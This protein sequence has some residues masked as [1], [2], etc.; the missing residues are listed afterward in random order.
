MP[1]ASKRESLETE[2]RRSRARGPA[3]AVVDRLTEPLVG[4]RH[5]GNSR[6]PDLIETAQVR[7][8]ICSGFDEV[9]ASRQV[10]HCDGLCCARRNWH[11]EREQRLVCFHS[12][13]IEPQ[14]RAR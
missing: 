7:E 10:A 1:A 2:E 3:Q 11:A 13:D 14:S 8:E 6:C 4:D 9:T 12:I 5:D